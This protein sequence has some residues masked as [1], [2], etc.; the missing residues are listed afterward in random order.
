MAT[1][2][3]TQ[4]DFIAAEIETP[5]GEYA[6]ELTD[7]ALEAICDEIAEYDERRQGYRLRPEYDDEEDGAER[8]WEIVE[9]HWP[10]A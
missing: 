10:E 1:I 4:P 8:F 7:E 2:Y 3:S 6:E 5:L 9:K